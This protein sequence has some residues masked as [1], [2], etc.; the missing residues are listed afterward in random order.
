VRKSVQAGSY[1]TELLCHTK[2]LPN[3]KRFIDIGNGTLIHDMA[4]FRVSG[5]GPHGDYFMERKADTL[6]SCH[7]EYEYLGKY[8]DCIDLNTLS[9]TFYIFPHGEDFSVTKM[10]LATEELYAYWQARRKNGTSHIVCESL[11]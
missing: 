2:S 7:I 1:R 10:A 3:A 11:Q 9:D 5:N 4:G 8:G 6:Y